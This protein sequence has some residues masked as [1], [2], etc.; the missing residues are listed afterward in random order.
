MEG[1]LI[2]TIRRHIDHIGYF[3]AADV[4]GRF[5]PGTGEIN[6]RNVVA[7]IEEAGFD[8]FIGLEFRPRG[9]AERSAEALRAAIAAMGG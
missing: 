1:N 3:H 2:A 7:A 6:Y 5:E 9:G 4:P 8:G